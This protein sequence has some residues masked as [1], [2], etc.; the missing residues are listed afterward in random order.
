MST[1]RQRET[2]LI[3]QQKAKLD[4]V[5]KQVQGTKHKMRYIQELIVQGNIKE[6]EYAVQHAC[7]TVDDCEADSLRP[8]REFPSSRFVARSYA[9][10]CG[11]LLPTTQS[12]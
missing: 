4:K 1:M 3:P 9:R 6:I 11:T 12:T 2:N 8:L 10:F 7:S 5:A